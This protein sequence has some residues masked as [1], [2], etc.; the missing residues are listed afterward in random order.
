LPPTRRSTVY[1]RMFTTRS[2]LRGA[3]LPLLLLP[4]ALLAQQTLKVDV[5]LVNVFVT[6]KDAGGQ[7]ETGLTKDDF[8]IYDDGEPQKI[9][10]FE[11]DNAVRSAIGVLLDTSGSVVDI[12][13]YET[14]GLRDFARS[15]SYPDEYLVITF[16]TNVRLI[17]R[18]PET[19]QH[20]DQVLLGLRPFGTSVLFDAMLYGI[21]RVNASDNERKALVVFTDGNDNGSNIEFGRVAQ[22]SQMSGVLLYFVAIGSPVLV[23]KHTV[24]SLAGNS[25]GR[26][27]YVP[28]AESVVPYLDEIRTEL[29]RQYYLAYYIT[30][31]PGYHRI[32]VDLP[33][34]SNLS[35][36]TRDGYLVGR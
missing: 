22:E 16:G 15:I 3:I 26:V 14:R 35:L 31:R 4:L 10:V 8:V 25:G 2:A 19:F 24:E 9:A 12:L 18:S 11:K 13:P 17:H 5:D 20:L 6:V 21:D 7:F 29:S 34:R 33:G 30:R 27:F 23:D 36:H 32:R 28:K 1:M